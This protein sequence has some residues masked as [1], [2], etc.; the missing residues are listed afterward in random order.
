MSIIPLVGLLQFVWQLVLLVTTY[1]SPTKQGLHDK[2][3]EQR[4]RPPGERRQRPRVTCL[5][6]ALVLP[7]LAILSIVALIFLGGQVSS[8]LSA[9][10]D[11][12]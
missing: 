9:V 6:V 1:S 12:V 7:V 8:I 11:S 10:G 2:F 4:S 5:V 3:A